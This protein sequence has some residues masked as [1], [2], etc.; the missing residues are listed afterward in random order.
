MRDKCVA[1]PSPAGKLAELAG[2]RLNKR[3]RARIETLADQAVE[4]GAHDLAGALIG[5]L[6]AADGDPDFEPVLGAPE[7]RP[8]DLLGY[9]VL[10]EARWLTTTDDREHDNDESEPWLGWTEAQSAGE[11]RP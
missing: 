7:L 1:N 11:A 10:D 4:L 8:G 9:R 5:L 3:R 2:I 6:D